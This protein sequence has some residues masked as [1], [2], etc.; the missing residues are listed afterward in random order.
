MLKKK[1]N[2]KGKGSSVT[3]FVIAALALKTCTMSYTGVWHGD[4]Y[5]FLVGKHT[6][7][8]KKKQTCL[9]YIG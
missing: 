2:L 8:L 6:G 4:T 1:K 7:T 3:V 5:S 9:A